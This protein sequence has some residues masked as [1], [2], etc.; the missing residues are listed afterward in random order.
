MKPAMERTFKGSF[1][2]VMKIW[3]LEIFPSCILCFSRTTLT[4]YQGSKHAGFVSRQRQTVVFHG[5]KPGRATQDCNNRQLG[6]LGLPPTSSHLPLDMIGS[7]PRVPTYKKQGHCILFINS[8]PSFCVTPAVQSPL[9][10][11]LTQLVGSK[12]KS[13][14]FTG[15]IPLNLKW[16]KFFETYISC[17]VVEC[18]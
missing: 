7:F 2:V 5:L 16:N 3:L 8:Q 10:N 9:Q 15:R 13:E 1:F 12:S 4:Q 14:S 18:T 11:V 6:L 17:G